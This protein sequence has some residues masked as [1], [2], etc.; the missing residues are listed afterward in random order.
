MKFLQGSWATPLN[1]R[2]LTL[3]GICTEG[4][5]VGGG[6]IGESEKEA[7]YLFLPRTIKRV[8]NKFERT[9]DEVML[10]AACCLGFF[11]FLRAR[12]F[13]SSR[14]HKLRPHLPPELWGVWQ[15]TAR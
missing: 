12:E 4:R 8:W 5:E 13:Y 3:V 15:S 7:T 6:N 14:R 1:R 9:K 11:G 2:V 10:R